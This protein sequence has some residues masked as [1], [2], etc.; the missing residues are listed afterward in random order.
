MTGFIN[1]MLTHIF[2]LV[3]AW[4]KKLL[5]NSLGDFSDKTIKSEFAQCKY[6][7]IYVLEYA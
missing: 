5:E 2:H 4:L 1:F 7:N 6:L 3:Q